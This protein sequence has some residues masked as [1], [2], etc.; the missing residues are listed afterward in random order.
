MT[1]SSSADYC[2]LSSPNKSIVID[3]GGEISAV[4]SPSGGVTL[5]YSD[6]TKFATTNTGV[7]ITGN[8]VGSANVSVPDWTGSVNAFVA[9]NS[10]D[11]VLYHD[12]IDSHIVNSHGT[13]CIDPKTGEK[14]IVLTP[15]GS[16]DLYYDNVKKLETTATGVK[17]T[18][19]SVGNMTTVNYGASTALVLT[20]SAYHKITLT[21]NI[22]FT[23]ASEAEGQSGSIFITQD[24]TGSR[25]ASWS[26][27]FKWP[28]GTAPTLSTAANAV[29]RIDYVVLAA[30]NIHCVATLDVK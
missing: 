30:A 18:G 24:G 12:S 14:G 22:A 5:K 21:G 15:D 11:L 4:F 23:C 13:L 10:N 3:G 27:D 17:V 7:S 1:Y 2:H 25:T 20:S 6:D 8:I 26:S 9:G 29:D 28:G 19:D 16:V